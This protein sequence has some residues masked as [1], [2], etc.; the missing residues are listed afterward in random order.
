MAAMSPPE[1]AAVLSEMPKGQRIRAL[2]SLEGTKG[3]PPH[4]VACFMA[5]PLGDQAE[6]L[7]EMMEEERH[8]E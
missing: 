1:A 8:H 6:T 2:L 4:R 7:R 5:M 3:Q